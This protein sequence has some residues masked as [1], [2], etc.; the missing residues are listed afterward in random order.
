MPLRNVLNSI[1]TKKIM[2]GTTSYTMDIPSVLIAI[3]NWNGKDDLLECL[4]SIMKLNYPKD[5]CKIL[6][7][8]NKSNDGSQAAVSLY[9]PEVSL[10]ENERNLGY[11]RAV[12]Q[13]IAYGMEREIDY[14]WVFNNDVAVEK[15]SLKRLIEVG[16]QDENIG[17]IAPV[18]YSYSNPETI[19]NI[20]YKINFWT[21]RLKKLKCGR[22]IFRNKGDEIAKVDSILGC[23]NLIKT[24]VFKKI[25]SFQTIYGVYFEETDFNVRAAQKGF[26]VVVVKEARVWHKNA[27]TMN[28]FIFRRAY[29]LLRNLFLFELLNAKL[30]HLL[31]FIPY[32]FFIHIPYFL[33]RGGIYGLLVKLTERK[34]KEKQQNNF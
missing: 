7:I 21:G 19:D 18:V 29:L 22:D 33:L 11:V 27:S 23:S 16:Q 1:M 26:R 3:V 34:R 20:G 2:Y 30:M 5:N 24:S 14:I 4:A 8:D 25:G 10:I 13:G 15:D 28:K 12:N 31:V 6:V 9:Y 17:V 32:Y